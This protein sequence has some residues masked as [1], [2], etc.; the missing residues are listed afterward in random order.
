MLPDAP[1]IPGLVG[2]PGGHRYSIHEL[3]SF[4]YRNDP[5]SELLTRP[6]WAS[7]GGSSTG[8]TVVAQQNSGSI[9]SS[10]TGQRTA[11]TFYTKNDTDQDRKGI[12]VIHGDI[13][14]GAELDTELSTK[15]CER[16]GNEVRCTVDFAKG[17][18]KYLT[19][20]YKNIARCEDA[21]AL[22]VLKSSNAD[23]KVTMQVACA[24]IDFDHHTTDSAL[25]SAPNVMPEPVE[26][27]QVQPE[28]Y[29][30]VVMP[31][32][33]GENLLF[34][35]AHAQEFV[36]LPAPHQAENSISLLPFFVLASIAVVVLGIA[37]F[38]RR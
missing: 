7:T 2:C 26:I 12:T 24:T 3:P 19:A 17:E 29:R 5:P 22:Q 36:L 25:T 21:P 33:G 23:N 13:P 18:T 8:T 32:T 20:I 11:Y 14:Q 9:Q 28:E 27:T 1:C 37:G 35:T 38:A 4:R 16:V 30:Q 6:L 15:G 31:Q 34:E 10:P